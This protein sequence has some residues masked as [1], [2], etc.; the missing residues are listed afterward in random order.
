MNALKY[1]KTKALAIIDQVEQWTGV[2]KDV[3]HGMTQSV[4]NTALGEEAKLARQ[5]AFL[6]H[7]AKGFIPEDTYEI[8][9]STEYDNGYGVE[10]AA[11]EIQVYRDEE[12]RFSASAAG[13]HFMTELDCEWEVEE[14]DEDELQDMVF[15]QAIERRLKRP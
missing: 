5:C 2:D 15:D 9:Y 13:L 14:L 7:E 4:I 10:S 8:P 11:D 6:E 3:R 12:G 1:Y